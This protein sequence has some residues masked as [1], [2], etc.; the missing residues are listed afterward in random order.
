MVGLDFCE[1]TGQGH[2]PRHPKA[3]VSGKKGE[4]RVGVAQGAAKGG[5]L[6]EDS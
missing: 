1:G 5:R 3:K 6:W 4:T 2:S